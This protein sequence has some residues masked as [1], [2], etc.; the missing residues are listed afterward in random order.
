MDD[1]IRQT[2]Q[3]LKDAV[4]ESTRQTLSNHGDEQHQKGFRS[5]AGISL[6]LIDQK[7][8]AFKEQMKGPGLSKTEQAIYAHLDELKSDIEANFERY[9]RGS[10]VNWRPP[11]PIAKGV[12]RKPEEL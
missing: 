1:R 10:G 3:F 6:R 11:K 5:A 2:G 12:L 4:Q 7:I 9:W 8:D